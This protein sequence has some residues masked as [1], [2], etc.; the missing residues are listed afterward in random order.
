MNIYIYMYIYVYIPVIFKN[1]LMISIA[2][3]DYIPCHA[4][5]WFQPL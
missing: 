2:M 5:W 4:G 3:F 1:I